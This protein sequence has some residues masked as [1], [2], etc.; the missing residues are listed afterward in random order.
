MNSTSDLTTLVITSVSHSSNKA[1]QDYARKTAE[2][3]FRYVIAGDEKSPEN[4]FLEGCHFLS[5]EKQFESG[6]ALAQ[7]LPVRHYSR[8]NIGYLEAMRAGS[9]VIVETDDDNY[10]R[11]SFWEKR[12]PRVQAAL[13]ENKGWFNVY[14]L[15]SGKPVWPRGFDLEHIRDVPDRTCREGLW[16]CPVQQGLA[17]ENPDVDAIYRMTQPL[18]VSFDSAPAVAIG[19]N[20]WCPFNSQNTTWFKE[21]FLLMY[22]PSYC[23][24]RMT[25]IWRSFVAQRI[26]WENEM[27]VLFHRATVWQERNIHNLLADFRD[28]IPGYVNNG[29]IAERLQALSLRKGTEHIPENLLACYQVFIDSNLMDSKELNLIR[30]W[31]EDVLSLTK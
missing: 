7:L 19:N 24:F 31:I 15:F 22:L 2:H 5:L 8:K 3:G 16:N 13:H 17:D 14:G 11:P 25:D 29:L 28:E 30:A 23:S 4:F 6:F 10:A 21:A 1:L 9:R 12:T 27:Y 18:P 20:T 26:C